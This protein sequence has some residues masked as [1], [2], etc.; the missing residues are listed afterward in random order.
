MAGGGDDKSTEIFKMKHDWIRAEY[1][2]LNKQI[3]AWSEADQKIIAVMATLVVAIIGLASSK[4]VTPDGSMPSY[5][6]FLTSIL[7]SLASIQS[8][9]YSSLILLALERKYELA[10]KLKEFLG[11]EDDIALTLYRPADTEPFRSYKQGV[12]PYVIFRSTM[13]LI[14]VLVGFA[15]ANFQNYTPKFILAGLSTFAL[16]VATL[17]IAISHLSAFRNFLKARP[18]PATPQPAVVTVDPSHLS[19]WRTWLKRAPI[20]RPKSEA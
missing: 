7:M 15:Y 17:L 12:F 2:L 1:D 19:A 8:S 14:L 3:P 18:R 20:F 6:L 4:Y 9:L 16:A 10:K 13:P 11:C 5:M